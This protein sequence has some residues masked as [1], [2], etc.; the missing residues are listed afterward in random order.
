MGGRGASSGYVA[1]MIR[2]NA[3]IWARSQIGSSDYAYYAKLGNWKQ[4]SYKCNAFVIRA[5]NQNIIPSVIE[6]HSNPWT[7]GITKIPYRA[8]DFY[9]GNVPGFVRVYNPMPGDI[10]SNGRHVGIVSGKNKTISASAKT[11]TVIENDWGF[12]SKK[13]RYYRYTG[14]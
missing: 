1:A 3:L 11:N 10:V 9:E 14:K 2:E 13:Y 12:G 8:K 5:F 6:N 7:L 4:N